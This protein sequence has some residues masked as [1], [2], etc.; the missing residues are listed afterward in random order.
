MSTAT[1]SRLTRRSFLKVTALAGGGLMVATCFDPV[2]GLFAQAPQGPAP[3][4][5]ANAF[6]KITPEGVVT[7]IAKNPEIGQGVKTSLPMLIAE[8]LDVPWESVRIEQA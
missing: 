1:M 5:A 2:S 4:F 7:I 3:S 6:V 8:E